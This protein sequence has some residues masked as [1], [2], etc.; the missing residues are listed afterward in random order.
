MRLPFGVWGALLVVEDG[1]VERAERLLLRAVRLDPQAARGYRSLG[2]LYLRMGERE[3][4]QLAFAEARRL[5]TGR[6]GK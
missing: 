4:A 1:D 5:A 3:Q 6:P 2:S